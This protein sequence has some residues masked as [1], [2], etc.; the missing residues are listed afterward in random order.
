[1]SVRL[2]LYIAANERF[3]DI[4]KNIKL[5]IYCC[6]AVGPNRIN[7]KGFNDDDRPKEFRHIT[8]FSGK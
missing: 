6:F 7:I 1:M 4:H 8:V 5:N 3:K 2:K